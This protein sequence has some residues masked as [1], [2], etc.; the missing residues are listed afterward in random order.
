MIS[1]I[2]PVYHR[3]KNLELVMAS[4]VGQINDSEEALEVIVADDGGQD[5]V[6][7]MLD[8]FA[9]L[10]TIKYVRMAHDGFQA[11][12]MRNLGAKCA[13]GGSLL[14]IDSDVLLNP[15]AIDNFVRLRRKYPQDI[16]CGRYDWLPPML[17]AMSDVLL[18]WDR[19]VYTQLPR[20]DMNGSMYLGYIGPDPRYIT[21][22]TLFDKEMETREYLTITFSGNL[23]V[24]RDMF[25]DVGGFDTE[26]IGH[27][28]EDCEL[29]IRLYSYGAKAVFSSAVCG[30][31]IWHSRDQDRNLKELA[32]NVKYIAEKYDLQALGLEVREVEGSFK[33]VRAT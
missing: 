33:I 26:M 14:F 16:I 20:I 8:T 2:I 17:I 5:N 25:F 11:G 6:P 28:G 31:H 3:R 10:I 7:E 15:N 32:K 24:P 23:L 19:V 27:G 18:R 9:S 1:I 4:I 13:D 30:Y 29:G 22:P 12:R 21:H